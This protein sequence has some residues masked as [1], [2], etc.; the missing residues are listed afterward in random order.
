MSRLEEK[1]DDLPSGCGPIRKLATSTEI[2]STGLNQYG[3]YIYE[4]FLKQ[5]RGRRKNEVFRE[6][7]DNDYVV[8]AVLFAIDM[9]IRNVDWTFEAKDPTNKD[10]VEAAEFMETVRED[11]SSTWTETV[12]E[13]LSML[14]Y[15]WSYHE[16]VF[17][18][19]RGKT[20]KQD[21]TSQ[22]DDGKVG[23]AKLP[24]RGQTT[25]ERQHGLELGMGG[26]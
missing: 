20:S 4:E 26:V 13:I 11:M 5:L 16:I 8:G 21:T 19:R 25:L 17:K 12:S 18:V 24:I 1:K 9:L 7:M 14:G 2:G 22:Y 15:G 6:M 3:G 10:D 23:W